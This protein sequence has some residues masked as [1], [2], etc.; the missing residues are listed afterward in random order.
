MDGPQLLGVAAILAAFATILG[1][2]FAFWRFNKLLEQ[3]HKDG[4]SARDVALST[5]AKLSRLVGQI[6]G[7]RAEAEGSPMPAVPDPTPPVT[8]V[9]KGT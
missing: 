9:R 4:N 5:Q 1:N 8:I 3:V 7:Q 2:L 6:E